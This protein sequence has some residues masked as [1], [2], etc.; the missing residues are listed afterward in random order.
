MS[1]PTKPRMVV[2]DPAQVLHQA[3]IMTPET[4]L[5]QRPADTTKAG[6]V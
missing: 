3:E 6:D 5:G 4:W 1:S 2:L